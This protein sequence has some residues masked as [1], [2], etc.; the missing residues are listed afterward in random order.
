VARRFHG[1]GIV[2][3]LVGLF[4]GMLS[5]GLF[6]SLTEPRAV[7]EQLPIKEV[8]IDKVKLLPGKECSASGH[9]TPPTKDVT[10]WLLRESLTKKSGRFTPSPYTAT[11]LADGKWQQSI[12]MWDDTFHIHAVVTTEES[13]SFYRWY[14][15]A[16]KAALDHI[17]VY[18]KNVKSVKDWPNLDS[19]PKVCR[20]DTFP[21]DIKFP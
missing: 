10:V 14:H 12:H 4:F 13:D 2:L 15:C 3:I 17:H 11:T 21:D 1:T 18:D 16:L 8:H 19:L 5:F 6:R 7:A 20:S 9:V